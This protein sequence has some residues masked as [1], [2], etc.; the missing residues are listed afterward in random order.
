[1]YANT[2]LVAKFD[3]LTAPLMMSGSDLTHSVTLLE[4]KVR[5]AVPSLLGWSLTVVVDGRDVTMNSIN[6]LA[7]ADD[8]RASIRVPLSAFMTAGPTGWMV[9]YAE[10]AHAFFRVGSDF[11]PEYGPYIC[12]L[13]TDQEHNPN[14]SSNLSGVRE[15][16]TILR[17][18]DVLLAGGYTP[19]TAR[20]HLQ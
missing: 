16:S 19:E 18:I 12:L 6:P 1:M 7:S 5:L 11:V 2:L 17:A 3:R 20:D 8:V 9:F 15:M 4:K 13:R 10:A 14:L